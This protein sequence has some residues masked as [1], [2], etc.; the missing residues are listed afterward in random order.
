MYG[1]V[2]LVSL[3]LERLLKQIA[4]LEMIDDEI[5][6]VDM[7]HPQSGPTFWDM[8]H[9]KPEMF[10][11]PEFRFGRI[12]KDVKRDLVPKPFAAEK[13]GGNDLRE[14]LI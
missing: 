2:A 9:E 4:L 14:D 13:L 12:V 3:H 8:G 1:L 10:T 11:Y 7:F 6:Q 5:Q